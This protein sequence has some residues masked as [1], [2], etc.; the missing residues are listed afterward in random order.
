MPLSDYTYIATLGQT[1]AVNFQLARAAHDANVPASRCAGPFD[2]M[3]VNLTQV[4][5]VIADDLSNY[6]EHDGITLPAEQDPEDGWV[7]FEGH[8]I[9]SRHQLQ[10]DAAE[11]IPTAKAW[12]EFGK[13]LGARISSW[14]HAMT[15]PT[16]NLLFVRLEDPFIL[17]DP[18]DV[19][20]LVDL[21]S[22]R[23]RGRVTFAWVRFE[24][25]KVQLA[26]PSVKVFAVRPAWSG[27]LSLDEIDW[28]RDY[29]HGIAW[30]G[31]NDDW[32][33]VNRAL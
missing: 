12:F 23:A 26:H 2:W 15:D 31:R 18:R 28:M 5:E 19:L 33:L 7:L 10:R 13:W 22:A 6:F 4:I 20:K 8:G 3:S 21:L 30:R 16:G 14:K 32:D 29:G 9:E 27:N 1:C 17:D 11:P 25:S 24:P